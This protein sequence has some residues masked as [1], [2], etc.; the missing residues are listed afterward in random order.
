VHCSIHSTAYDR[1]W[2]H[3]LR[4]FDRGSTVSGGMTSN[5]YAGTTRNWRTVYA[6]L[7]KSLPNSRCHFELINARRK[8]EGSSHV[9]FPLPSSV[10]SYESDCQIQEFIDIG[11]L[12]H[13][14]PTHR[15]WEAGSNERGQRPRHCMEL[16]TLPYM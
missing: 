3:R 10:T 6:S 8:F 12:A 4:T 1:C 15:S 14:M 11:A 9:C 5:T 7:Y 16:V 13:G 2:P